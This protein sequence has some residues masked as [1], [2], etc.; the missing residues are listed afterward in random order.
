[1]RNYIEEHSNRWW[2]RWWCWLWWRWE[3]KL[4]RCLIQFTHYQEEQRLHSGSH[5][6]NKYKCMCVEM[7]VKGGY[8]TARKSVAIS[9]NTQMSRINRI[10]TAVQNT[11]CCRFCIITCEMRSNNNKFSFFHIHFHFHSNFS[12]CISI[13]KFI[14]SPLKHAFIIDSNSIIIAGSYCMSV[15]VCGPVKHSPLPPL[16]RP[17]RIIDKYQIQLKSLSHHVI[18]TEKLF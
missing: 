16:R 6:T 3:A 12:L 2:W 5:Q 17:R 11:W 18:V 1:M 7:C 9:C 4:I 13:S 14:E 8:R 10:T 15:W